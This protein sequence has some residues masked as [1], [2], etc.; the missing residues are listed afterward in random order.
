[1]GL[2]PPPLQ[3]EREKKIFPDEIWLCTNQNC[4][5]N[6]CMKIKK[7]WKH[8]PATFIKY[9]LLLFKILSCFVEH[10]LESKKNNEIEKK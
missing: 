2:S 3:S 1:M 7:S 8:R 10:S 6:V 4:N 9:C 5:Y